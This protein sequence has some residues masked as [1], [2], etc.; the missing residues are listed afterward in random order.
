MAA[1][2]EHAIHATVAEEHAAFVAVDR[3]LRPHRHGL[4]GMFVDDQVLH[5]VGASDHHL[6]DAALEQNP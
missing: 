2:A 1:S 4:V 5:V 3:E 6:A